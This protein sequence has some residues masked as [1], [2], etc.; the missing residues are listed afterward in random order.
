MPR[1]VTILGHF[2]SQDIQI[3]QSL[4][5]RLDLLR[6]YLHYSCVLRCN[7][8]KAASVCDYAVRWDA[9]SDPWLLTSSAI[10]NR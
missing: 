4:L 6:N 7:R 10:H 1:L 8:I 9:G 5:G 2:T 3:K